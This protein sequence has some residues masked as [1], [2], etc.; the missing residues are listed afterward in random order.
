MVDCPSIWVCQFSHD[1][2]GLLGKYTTGRSAHL[3]VLYQE[4]CDINVTYKCGDLIKCRFS[5]SEVQPEICISNEL[6]GH[7]NPHNNSISTTSKLRL[8]KVK[9][10][11]QGRSPVNNK[12]C[13]LSGELSL[14]NLRI[15]PSSCL[16]TSHIQPLRTDSS[17]LFRKAQD[18]SINQRLPN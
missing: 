4:V 12:E 2:S 6:L 17:S 5:R 13:S 7:L 14:T 15:L 11:S 8:R 18:F 16:W 9:Y 10:I 1:Y 3:I